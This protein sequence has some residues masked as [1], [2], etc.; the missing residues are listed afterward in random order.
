MS[1]YTTEVRFICETA[2]G[3]TE[4]KGYDKIEEIISAA[5]SHIFDFSYPLFDPNYKSVIETKI[6]RHFYTREIG[7][8]TVGLW[9]HFLCRKMNEIMPYYNKLYQSE[10]LEFNPFYDV[11]Y[12]REGNREGEDTD[13]RNRIGTGKSTDS[14]TERLNIKDEPKTDA[15]EYYSDTPQGGVGDLASMDY[16][17]NATHNTVSGVGSNRDDV[18]T[19]GKIV[20]TTSSDQESGTKNTTEE[21]LERVHGKQGSTPYSELL[22]QYRETFLNI[23]MMVIN[24]LE[25]LFMSLW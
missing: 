12:T 11:D 6:L 20:D 4:S 13:S 24:E 14:G 5:R 3:Y 19:F 2:A 18:T 17:T 23:D 16:M 22:Q 7:A 9:K 25:P 10:L 21:Y 15:W 1:K 8:E